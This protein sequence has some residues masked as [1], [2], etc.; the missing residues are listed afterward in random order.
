MRLRLLNIAIGLM[1]LLLLALGAQSAYAQV[2]PITAEVDRTSLSVG[3]ILT[4]TVKIVGPS[5]L[6][7][8]P[9]P[10]LDGM[11]LIDKITSSQINIVDGR[12]TTEVI[13][14][15]RLR[16]TRAGSLTIGS[17]SV[18][19][20]DH[21]FRTEPI[22]LEVSD[23]TAS[24]SGPDLSKLTGQ[25]FFVEAQVDK[26]TP[27]VGEQVT[28]I[29]RFYRA[30]E[31][32]GQPSY[33]APAFTGFWHSPE[34]DRV[35][36]EIQAAGRTYRVVETRT[37]LFPSIIG[38]RV[39]EP[40]TLSIPGGDPG[41]SQVLQTEPITLS[42]AS[43][44]REAPDGFEG[45]IGQFTITARADVTAVEVNEPILTTVTISGQGNLDTLPD[46]VWPELP[47]WRAF[48]NSE[49][50]STQIG[51]G[52]LT[53]SKVYERVHVPGVSGEFAIPAIPYTFFDPAEA[54]YVTVS[55][56]PIPVSIGVDPNA[57]AEKLAVGI[58]SIKPAPAV[59]TS[60]SR[61]F[62]GHV[63]YWAAW[64]APLFPLS[65]AI[66]WKARSRFSGDT[67]SLRSR[68]ARR[69]ARRALAQAR[70]KSANP[71]AASSHILTRYIEDRLD[72]P[73][74]G[75]TRGRLARLLADRGISSELGQRVVECLALCE[76]GRYAPDGEAGD[77]GV[78]LLKETRAIITDLDREIGR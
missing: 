56:E 47:Q 60:A 39:I 13:H 77:S 74:A 46:P 8:S 61:P 38:P 63:F 36:F 17:F 67:A 40:S 15:Y 24:T 78:N 72:Q 69:A 51:D 10:S 53:G 16:P 54:K 19:I 21:T 71:C 45:A 49:T 41:A 11:I 2:S 73:V 5:D 33:N 4:L 44:P 18:T 43:L 70:R 76:V 50:V 65:V 59:L 37:V 68:N 28:Y 32:S 25:D 9:L 35:Q 7:P 12:P 48:V 42:V 3:D 22:A 29:V 34:S 30:A 27:F 55:T 26:T 75:V 14:R 58:R 57:N 20:N 6:E 62:T 23:G 52:K 1:A 31:P 66:A 64:A